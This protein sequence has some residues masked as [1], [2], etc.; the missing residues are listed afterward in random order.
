MLQ[1]LPMH[2]RLADREPLRR[3]VDEQ[4]ACMRANRPLAKRD[5]TDGTI[6]TTCIKLRSAL[7][8]WAADEST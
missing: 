6:M 5:A 3:L 4:V 2:G 7:K 8:H 1:H